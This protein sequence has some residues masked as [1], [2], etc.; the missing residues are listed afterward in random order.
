MLP[1]ARVAVGTIQADADIQGMLWALIEAFRAK[2]LQVQ[3]FLSRACFTAYHGS[4]VASGLSPR[5]LD[6][7]LMSPEVCREIFVRGAEDSDLAVVQGEFAGV[8][9]DGDD[10]G[11]S[12]NTLCEWLDLP[13]LVV[14]DIC[15]AQ[16][17]PL[18]ERPQ[19]VDAVLLDRV[20]DS[21]ELARVTAE[22]EGCWGVPV[23]GALEA[24]PELRAEIDGL[25][26]GSRPPREL[27]RQLGGHLLRHAQPQRVLKL[28]LQRELEWGLPR[29]YAEEP[30]SC[31]PVV[32][33]A[34]DDAMDCD[35]PDTLDLLE[36]RGATI[37]DFSPL[38]DDRLPAGTDI[39]YLGCGRPERYAAELSRN[40]CMKLALRD[41]LRKGG[42]VYAEGGGLA[43]LCQQI[44]LGDGEM[45]RMVG[46]FPAIACANHGDGVPAPVEV[47]V[48]E[49]TWL[50]PQGARLRGYSIPCWRLRA[51]GPLRGCGREAELRY[52]LVKSCGAIGSQ[53]HL[54]FAAQ[55]ELL[56]SFFQAGL[57][58]VDNGDPW[59][60]AG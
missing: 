2:G 25:P 45:F 60:A 48:D 19:Q 50:A 37:V 40:H 3:S 20:V 39:V 32:A 30:S 57:S 51:A 36:T 4:G 17:G 34:Y 11:G 6:S 8:P 27:C 9:V 31:R 47:T 59:T 24:L 41:H 10:V 7:W 58:Q 38:R 44:Q 5:H 15:G 43:Y 56:A 53:I 54:N 46:I 12:L 33:L 26:Q 16:N 13:R 21:Q 18:P 52:A 1:L 29:L 49:Q 55:P 23:L 42:R 35:F 22:L 14:L 28:A